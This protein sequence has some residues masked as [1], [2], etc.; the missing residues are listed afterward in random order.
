MAGR[1]VKRRGSFA[2]SLVLVI[3]RR[4]P[5]VVSRRNDAVLCARIAADPDVKLHRCQN[6]LAQPVCA[7]LRTAVAACSSR[8]S[9]E[10]ERLRVEAI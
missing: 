6:D 9:R 3:G 5:K 4:L 10:P 8:V 7:H 1:T 2:Q